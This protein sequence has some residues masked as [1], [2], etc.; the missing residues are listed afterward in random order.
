MEFMKLQLIHL[1]NGMF[2]ITDGITSSNIV[3]YDQIAT[4]HNGNILGWTDYWSSL[5]GA[6][7][8]SVNQEL[9]FQE[10]DNT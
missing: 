5:G 2:K 9:R 7:I 3:P 8:I 4:M 10:V 1:P 6:K